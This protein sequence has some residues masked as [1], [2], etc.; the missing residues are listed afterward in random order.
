VTYTVEDVL[1]QGPCEAWPEARIRAFLR[2]SGK[3]SFTLSDVVDALEAAGETNDLE[4]GAGLLWLVEK[5]KPTVCRETKQFCVCG[6]EPGK[7]L[8]EAAEICRRLLEPLAF[9]LR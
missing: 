2:C 4:V 1:A 5:L 8:I 6:C 3:P 9:D 7:R